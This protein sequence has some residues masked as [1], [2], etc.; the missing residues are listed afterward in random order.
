M[1]MVASP[2]QIFRSTATSST[3]RVATTL[4]GIHGRSPY[5]IR[6][7]SARPRSGHRPE[8]AEVGRTGRPSRR[9]AVEQG[10]AADADPGV[11]DGGGGGPLVEAERLALGRVHRGVGRP[12]PAG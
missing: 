9:S 2:D 12:G 3:C 5:S 10:P 1:T 6:T 11:A 8:R 4:L 7:P